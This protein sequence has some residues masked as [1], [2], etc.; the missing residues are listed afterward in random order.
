MK[1]SLFGKYN[2]LNMTE[3]HDD[4]YSGMYV[5]NKAVEKHDS[6]KCTLTLKQIQKELKKLTDQA[7][8]GIDIDEARFDYL[9]RAQEHNEEYKQI[10]AE[11]R[12]AWRDS[13]Y[14]FAEQCLERTRSFVPV[15]IF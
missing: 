14:E 9:L 1:S 7:H 13:V 6:F 11:E 5:A 10:L 8:Q 2:I 3:V 4:E 12:A 15:N